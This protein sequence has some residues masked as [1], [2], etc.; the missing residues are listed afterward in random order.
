MP[1]LVGGR[2]VSSL[3]GGASLAILA[4]VVVLINAGIVVAAARDRSYGALALI[5]AIGPLMNAAV[6]LVSL[7]CTPF[8]T[9]RT[10]H[11]AASILMP[12]VAGALDY[13]IV[14]FGVP[15]HGH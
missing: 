7:C 4:A 10:R 1:L 3:R 6:A 9:R 11:V 13:L 15:L 12:A 8:V 2:A 5:Y 14:L